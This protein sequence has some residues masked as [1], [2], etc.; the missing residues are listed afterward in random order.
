MWKR[1]CR[2]DEIPPNGL[3]QLAVEGGPSIV[4]ANAGEEFF[5]CQAFCP[6]TEVPLA[7]GVHDGSVLTC[8]EHLWQFDLRTGAAIGEAEA[9]VTV[10]PLKREDG[11]LY[12]WV[13][14][15]DAG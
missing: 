3:K 2:P 12:V 9:P 4:I 14:P 11:E 5:A 7:D 15:A 6:H 10:Y 1:A 8:L 13:E